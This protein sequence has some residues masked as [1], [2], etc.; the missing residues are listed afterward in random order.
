[1][2]EA[3]RLLAILRDARG[4]T[5]VGEDLGAPL[6]E[7]VARA[8]AAHPGLDVPAERFVRHLAARLPAPISAAQLGGLHGEDLYLACACACGD[9]RALAEF[10]RQFLGGDLDRAIARITS[11]PPVV[12][13]VRQLLRVKLFVNDEGRARIV[14]YSGRGPLAAWLRVA[15]VRTALN[16]VTRHAPEGSPGQEEPLLGVA[17]PETEYL[18]TQ[19][20]PEFE[21]AFRAALT[22]LSVEQRQLLRFHYVDGLTLAQIGRLRQVHEST[23]SRRLLAARD[24]LLAETRRALSA[25]L[26]LEQAEVDSLM[27]RVMSRAEVTLSTLF[28][29]VPG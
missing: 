20:R 26:R 5:E 23:I 1:V 28:R 11:A 21:Q 16:L 19:H 22:T 3:E 17:D 14:D 2:S 18:K 9:A 7:L 15:A 4:A 6:A 10:D 24:Q 8:R 27:G 12:E 29:S 25:E 13:E